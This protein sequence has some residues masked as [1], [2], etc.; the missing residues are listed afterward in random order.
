MS[1][2]EEGLRETIQRLKLAQTHGRGAYVT[3]TVSD[4]LLVHLERT[5][6]L[7]SN[8][9]LVMRLGCKVAVTEDGGHERPARRRGSSS[10]DG[11]R[12]RSGI[13]L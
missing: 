2:A 12:R 11:V 8:G 5:N 3:Q 4:Q 13:D 1:D 6:K 7:D 10:A 9:R